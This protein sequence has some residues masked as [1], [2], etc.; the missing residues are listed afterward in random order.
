MV[1]SF[2]LFVVLMFMY[3]SVF[4]FRVVI[5]VPFVS[6]TVTLPYVVLLFFFCLLWFVLMVKKVLLCGA[7]IPLLTATNTV[8]SGREGS[9]IALT[10]L[11]TSKN[12][13]HYRF[14]KAV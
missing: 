2:L 9:L 10:Y 4:R 5:Y 12:I 14:V 6:V 1:V 3:L 7:V 8:S 13:N 11:R